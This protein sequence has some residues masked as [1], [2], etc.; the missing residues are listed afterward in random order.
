MMDQKS[1]E[2]VRLKFLLVLTLMLTLS[3]CGESNTS[4]ETGDTTEL[5]IPA[6]PETE[7]T[8]IATGGSITY[9]VDGQFSV[10]IPEDNAWEITQSENLMQ[11]VGVEKTWKIILGTDYLNR[12]TAEEIINE[13]TSLNPNGDNGPSIEG[14]EPYS[15]G[16]I[17]GTKYL[18]VLDEEVGAIRILFNSF[19]SKDDP[20]GYF[21]LIF[22]PRVDISEANAVFYDQPIQS[23]LS[24]IRAPE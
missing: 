19:I 4:N 12:K 10:D 9:K 3:A 21:E 23:I 2:T 6:T 13:N 1:K 24:S 14:I 7:E 15:I 11:I 22:A 16:N 18:S 5:S 17:S 8:P 20:V